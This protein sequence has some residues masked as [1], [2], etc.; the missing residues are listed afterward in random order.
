MQWSD[1]SRPPAPRVL[2]QFGLLCF[3]LGTAYFGWRAWRGAADA[4]AISALTAGLVIGVAGLVRPML[5]RWVFTGWMML[6]FPIGWTISK[7]VLALMFFVMFTPVA[8]VFRAIG[9][10]PLRQ[11]RQAATGS[12]W[13]QKPAARSVRDYFRQF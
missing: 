13:L 11:R 1:V 7:V 3:A 10:D 6:A 4:W 12:L 9:R 2:R 8:L 5:L